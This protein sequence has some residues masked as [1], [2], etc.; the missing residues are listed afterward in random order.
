MGEKDFEAFRQN[1]LLD[2]YWFSP[3]EVKVKNIF[4]LLARAREQEM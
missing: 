4:R 1:D 2:K 3:P